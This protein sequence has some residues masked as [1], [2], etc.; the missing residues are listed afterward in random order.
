MDT[1]SLNKHSQITPDLRSAV[2]NWYKFTSG[3]ITD[4]IRISQP[5]L[6]AYFEGLATM[7]PDLKGI[8]RKYCE[9]P[10]TE[11][12]PYCVCIMDWDAFQG[13][14]VNGTIKINNT[15]NQ[16]VK[17]KLNPEIFRNAH[18]D[19]NILPLLNPDHF[20]LSPGESKIVTITVN[21]S[22]KFDHNSAYTSEIKVRGRY[23][24]C[25]RL[26]LHVRRR[27]AP[28]C[29]I[30]HGEI[31]THIVAHHWYDHFQCEQMCFKPIEMAK[32]NS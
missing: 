30:H 18:D 11:C 6:D 16:N 1:V 29:V 31:P 5:L 24:Q 13:D 21:V 25:I 15:G 3:S 19:S 10:E 20:D 2:L 22:D 14:V 9:I 28:C 23:E 12:P 4:F 32:S 17:F 26:N 27:V 8:G 7:V